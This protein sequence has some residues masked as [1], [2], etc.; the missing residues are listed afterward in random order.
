[1][2]GMGR[3]FFAATLLMIAGMLNV[4]YGIGALDNANIFANDQRYV[5]TDLNTM[6]W[7][8]I[9]VGVLQ[10]SGGISLYV[11]NTW[12]RILGIAGAS[13][14]AITALLSVGGNY[15]WWSLGIFFLCLYILHGIFIYGD[16]ERTT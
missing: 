8:L 1:M 15:P 2:R 12:G 9:V 13:V 7:A 11:G 10:L 14:G 16:D 6:G 5:F 4:I 3:A